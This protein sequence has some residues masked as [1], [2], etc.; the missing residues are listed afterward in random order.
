M[1]PLEREILDLKDLL[2][3][4]P[5]SVE[6]TLAIRAVN[7]ARSLISRDIIRASDAFVRAK[8]FYRQINQSVRKAS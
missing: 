3:V 2:H 7:H 5:D 4:M 6:R 1:S 8:R